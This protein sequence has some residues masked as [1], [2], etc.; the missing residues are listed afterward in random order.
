MTPEQRFGD[1]LAADPTRPFVTYYDEASGERSEL[2]ARSLANWVVKT[3]FLL[4][5]ELGL[6]AG[7]RALITLPAH[8]IS[9]PA[10][11]G[12]LTAGLELSESASAA[13]VAFVEPSSIPSAKG[14][15]DVYAVAPASAAV[16]FGDDVPSGAADFVTAVRPQPDKWPLVRFGAGPDDPGVDGRTRAEVVAEAESR[17]AA[18]GVGRGERMLTT[19]DWSGASDWL[20]TLLVPLVMAGSVVYVRNAPDE[21]TVTRRIE[22]ERASVRI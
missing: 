12:C 4:L 20:D 9:V 15:P 22:Q 14:V 1:L 6:G 8:W 5:D 11:L 16:G 19:R 21:A 17:A 10:V 3:H 2:S 13:A 18:L 7:D